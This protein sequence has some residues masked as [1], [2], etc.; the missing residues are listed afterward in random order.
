MKTHINQALHITLETEWHNDLNFLHN[1]R[2]LRNFNCFR[3]SIDM[4]MTILLTMEAAGGEY[5]PFVMVLMK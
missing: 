4:P 3:H 5:R 2:P 1:I